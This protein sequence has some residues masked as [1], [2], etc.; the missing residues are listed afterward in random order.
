[1]IASILIYG[2][3]PSS[4]L[5]AAILKQLLGI[6]V[7]LLLPHKDLSDGQSDEQ[8]ARENEWLKTPYFET[9]SPRALTIL[10]LLGLQ[11]SHW[12]KSCTVSPHLGSRL[13][14]SFND[15]IHLQ[16]TILP[17]SPIAPDINGVGFQHYLSALHN[18]DTLT[19]AQHTRYEDYS[20]A[21]AL[22]RRKAFAQ[23]VSDPNSIF[24]S[25]DIGLSVELCSFTRPIIGFARQLGVNLIPARKLH[26]ET[27]EGSIQS[28]QTAAGKLSAS[29]YIDMSEQQTLRGSLSPNNLSP[30][31]TPKSAPSTT[32]T[33]SEYNKQEFT[34]G[35]QQVSQKHTQYNTCLKFTAE[36][37]SKNLPYCDE[38]RILN[39]GLLLSH[40]VA[41]DTYYQYFFDRGAQ[42]LN[43]ALRDIKKETALNVANNYTVTNIP[44]NLSMPAWQGNVI[45][46]GDAQPRSCLIGG[47][48]LNHTIESLGHLI[49]LMPVDD[50]FSLNTQE[51][52]RLHMAEQCHYFDFQHTYLML[53]QL[54]SSNF[55][56]I[57]GTLATASSASLHRYTLFKQSGFDAQFEND[58]FEAHQWQNLMLAM[59]VSVNDIHPLVSPSNTSQ[60]AKAKQQLVKIK[61]L[62]KMAA[63]SR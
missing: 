3:S 10:G 33:V 23:P 43:T 25:Y 11:Q 8:R 9:L 31:L 44:Q 54:P 47:N 58:P 12:V 56:N 26:I 4:W 41:N 50:N 42:H 5:S 60:F 22:L 61:Q 37:N 30:H 38:L 46:M 21:C 28:I 18:I 57:F 59:G 1:M 16:D 13:L 15:H 20:L 53:N 63:E 7:H 32:D 19:S 52:N 35:V 40:S 51:Y 48:V 29:L 62:V 2:N 49:D 55:Y 17:H 36:T 27:K 14:N 45:V 34:H 39:N 6:E 24:S